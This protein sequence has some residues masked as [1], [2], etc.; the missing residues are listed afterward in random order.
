MSNVNA[1]VCILNPPDQLDPFRFRNWLQTEFSQFIAGVPVGDLI[2][3]VVFVPPA[4]R[5]G[6]GK[7]RLNKSIDVMYGKFITLI[8]ISRHDVEQRLSEDQV[9]KEREKHLV[10]ALEYASMYNAPS[11]LGESG[12]VPDNGEIFL[13]FA[14]GFSDDKAM[15]AAPD[16]VLACYVKQATA[17]EVEIFQKHDFKK[18]DWYISTEESGRYLIHGPF[19]TKD[20][21][22]SYAY[23]KFDV[24]RFAEMPSG[25]LS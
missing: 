19:P 15:I 22:F 21:A 11:P 13:G 12:S 9:E 25:S 17:Q 16:E 23:E 20:E 4:I 24:K 10:E 7:K 6:L 2:F 5:N 8:S 3:A 1:H 14:K 18:G